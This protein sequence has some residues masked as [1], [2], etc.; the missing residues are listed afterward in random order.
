MNIN[1][2]IWLTRIIRNRESKIKKSK[3]PESLSVAIDS[4]LSNKSPTNLLATL[5]LKMLKFQAQSDCLTNICVFAAEE[6]LVVRDQRP[7]I[8]GK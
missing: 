5:R 8:T 4:T 2:N 3:E 6:L 1:Q 7:G